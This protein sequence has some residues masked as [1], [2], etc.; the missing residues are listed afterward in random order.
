MLA[1]TAAAL[2]EVLF[3][4]PG[5][6]T[7]GSLHGPSAASGSAAAEA[8]ALDYL[9]DASDELAGCADLI[10]SVDSHPLHLHSAV[11]ATG[12]RVLRTAVCGGVR[13]DAASKTM[14]VQHA[15]EGHRLEDVCAFLRLLYNPLEA[16]QMGLEELER[17]LVLTDKLDAPIVLQGSCGGLAVCRDCVCTTEPV[18]NAASMPHSLRL[19]RCPL[20]CRPVMHVWW[21]CLSVHQPRRP[22]GCHWRTAT[23]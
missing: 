5:I 14:A 16:E 19:P 20:T 12:S 2:N 18:P 11:L 4:N 13:G 1:W 8:A 22:P 7:R 17:V 23:A 6:A 15:F 21:S 3:P 10:I 9:P